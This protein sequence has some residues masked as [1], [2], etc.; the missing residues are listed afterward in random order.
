V[1]ITDIDHT[2]ISVADLE[3]SISFYCDHLGAQLA[4]RLECGPDSP[5]GTV[6]GMPGASARIAHLRLGSRMIELFQYANPPGR[7][8]FPARDQADHGIV[9]VGFVS[10][11]TRADHAR[12]S[13]QGV[14]FLSSPVEF[15]PGVWIVYFHGPD[16]EVCELRQVPQGD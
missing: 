6:V 8:A 15:R 12:L 9:H 11:D 7:P 14:E 1:S 4:R 13:A 3:R 10:T 2:A 5:L 16:G